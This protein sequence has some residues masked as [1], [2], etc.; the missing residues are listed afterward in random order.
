MIIKVPIELSAKTF[1][2]KAKKF[3]DSAFQSQKIC[4]KS[5]Q[6]AQTK[7]LDKSASINK[8]Y[9]DAPFKR[10]L[11]KYLKPSYIVGFLQDFP[12]LL[13]LYLFKLSETETVLVFSDNPSVENSKLSLESGLQRLPLLEC[14]S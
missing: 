4:E 12:T 8:K 3:W 14:V 7:F 10:K 11:S 13:D 6:I 5:K 1:I 2:L 9:K